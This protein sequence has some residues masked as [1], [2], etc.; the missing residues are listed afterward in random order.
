M[1]EWA[2]SRGITLE[3]Q[4]AE[5]H[6]WLGVVERKHQVVR[7]A[8]ELYQDDCGRHDLNTLKEAAI[9]VAHA[10]NQ[11]SMVR[12][13]TPQQW[14]LGKTMTYAHGLSGE[15]FN[16]GQE[17]I[18]E[19]GAFSMI[20]KKRMA[21]QMAWIKAD[22]DAKLRRAFN[23]KFQDV[24]EALAVGQR[25]WYWR[26]AGSGILQKAKWRGPARVVAVEDREG[27]RVLWLCHGTSL[28]RCG[29]RQV[30]PLVEETGAIVEADRQAALRDLEE[31]KARS[32]TQFKDELQAAYGPNLEDNFDEPDYSPSVAPRDGEDEDREEQ[33]P[34]ADEDLLGEDEEL[35]A[36]PGILQMVMPRRE[37]QERERTP[38][39]NQD[40]E[41]TRRPSTATTVAIDDEEEE[42]RGRSP[43][44]RSEST[45]GE[46]VTQ[47]RTE[48]I[49][50]PSSASKPEGENVPLPVDDDELMVDVYIQDVIGEL[51]AGWRC[52]EGSLKWLMTCA[53]WPT[54]RVRST[55]KALISLVRRAL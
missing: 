1:R 39:R 22:S 36:L 45:E 19:A 38:R 2:S 48:A 13:F 7:R 35:N 27:T 8:L 32:T 28:I 12:G 30:K 17:A 14:V 43:K 33:E 51:P 41:V 3:V 20:Q 50:E 25:C 34:T 26:V 37:E 53:I 42:K 55:S 47:R 52:I 23:Q 29:E 10:I 6:S 4:P 31:L 9:Y 5:Q 40:Q 44:R 21:A 54:G 11:T 46:R 18:D 49:Q 16:P 15:I 24:K